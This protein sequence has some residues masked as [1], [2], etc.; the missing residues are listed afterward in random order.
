MVMRRRRPVMRAAMMG[1]AGYYAGKK[2]QEG[3]Q[4]DAYRD[5]RLDELERQQATAPAPAAA[6][7]AAGNVPDSTIET[8]KQLAQL[9]D[10]G[11]LTDDEF[12]AQKRKLLGG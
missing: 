9:H 11:V 3:R 6:A 5:A 8:L 2:M 12:A 7:P 10:Q 1:G 4:D